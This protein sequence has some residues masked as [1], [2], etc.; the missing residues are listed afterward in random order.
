VAP[1]SR[2]LVKS[3]EGEETEDGRIRVKGRIGKWEG[4]RVEGGRGGEA[5]GEKGT[6]ASSYRL[7]YGYA[8]A[9]LR[10]CPVGVAVP[11]F[12]G[13]YERFIKMLE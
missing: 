11:N 7:S 13:S 1:V 6:F 4:K 2:R 12:S 9:C 5:K 8:P 10:V 3:K